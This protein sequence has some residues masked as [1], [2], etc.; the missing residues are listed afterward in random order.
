MLLFF[1]CGNL[2]KR[3][4]HEKVSNKS[5][6]IKI[7]CDFISMENLHRTERLV[8]EFR[9][10]RLAS[11]WGDD[12]LQLYTS[13]WYA[14]ISLSPLD[15]ANAQV[16]VGGRP[17][18]HITAIASQSDPSIVS[19]SPSLSLPE[20]DITMAGDQNLMEDPASSNQGPNSFPRSR[21]P[22][23]DLD[24]EMGEIRDASTIAFST[25]GG[26]SSDAPSRCVLISG[27][28]PGTSIERV[29][30][31]LRNHS[32]CGIS[33]LGA[34]SYA[35]HDGTSY[36]IECPDHRCARIVCAAWDGCEVDNHHICVSCMQ[37]SDLR[38]VVI[39]PYFRPSASLNNLSSSQCSPMASR[40]GECS[41]RNKAEDLGDP[42]AGSRP[43]NPSYSHGG[44]HDMKSTLREPRL[45]SHLRHQPSSSWESSAPGPSQSLNRRERNFNSAMLRIA[46]REQSRMS[47]GGLSDDQRFAVNLNLSLANLNVLIGSRLPIPQESQSRGFW[48]R[49]K[50]GF[51]VRR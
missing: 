18:G 19:E 34:A 48:P 10:H 26:P 7:A 28:A 12:V 14:W 21:C 39:S 2:N 43:P 4:L 9:E 6:A 32:G 41:R 20:L 30:G 51:D 3:I 50:R 49:S 22:S 45:F 24:V 1:V 25:D 27:L 46:R 38:N 31:L 15:P 16:R 33:I 8:G 37:A 40:K 29:A 17:G 44:T 5:D 36:I 13:L 23:L 35:L 42:R 47:A 11:N